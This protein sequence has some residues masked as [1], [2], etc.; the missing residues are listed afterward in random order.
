M[1]IKKAFK[2]KTCYFASPRTE[3]GPA[4]LMEFWRY[5]SWNGMKKTNKH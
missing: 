5:T 3:G 4:Y 1:N 2:K